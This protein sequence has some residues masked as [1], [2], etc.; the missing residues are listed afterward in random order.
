MTILPLA[1][2]LICQG[3]LILLHQIA[4]LLQNVKAMYD[5][6]F[7]TSHLPFLRKSNK[8]TLLQIVNHNVTSQ[9]SEILLNQGIYQNRNY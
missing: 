1:H 9:I 2:Q 8:C 7:E 6:K 3:I 5:Q 4:K